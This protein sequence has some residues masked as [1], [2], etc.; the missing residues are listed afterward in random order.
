MNERERKGGCFSFWVREKRKKTK[1]KTRS[2]DKKKK[3][4]NSTHVL[5]ELGALLAVVGVRHARGPADHAA[6]ALGAVVALVAD[7]DEGGRAHEG[8]ADD[9]LAVAC[10]FFRFFLMNDEVRCCCFTLFSFQ[11]REKGNQTHI[12]RRLGR[13]LVLFG[14]CMGEFE[15]G[16]EAVLRGG[17]NRR[18]SRS[19]ENEWGRAAEEM[20]PCSVRLLSA[21][22][23]FF[24]SHRCLAACGTSRGRAGAPPS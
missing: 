17:E 2:L 18:R 19:K 9:A 14:T 10:F 24:D 15:D 13:W 8:V 5:L 21:L 16:D 4:K 11:M 22:S 7:A 12:F 20:M 23:L 3:S 6:P 1:K